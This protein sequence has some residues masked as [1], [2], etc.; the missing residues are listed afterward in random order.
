MRV[1]WLYERVIALGEKKKKKIVQWKNEEL[2]DQN[3]TI[4]VKK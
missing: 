4:I 3:G 2:K 1:L